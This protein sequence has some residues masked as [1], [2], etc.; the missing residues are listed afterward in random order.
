MSNNNL[1]HKVEDKKIIR[2]LQNIRTSGIRLTDL[3]N[4]LLDLSKLESGKMK[5][6]LKEQDL[7]LLVEQALSEVDSLLKEKLINVDIKTTRHFDCMIDR[8]L[9]TQVIIN[10]LSNS[11]KFSPEYS[12]IKI[13][14][15]KKCAY[16]RNL[17]PRQCHRLRH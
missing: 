3:L 12:S 5:A 17:H 4:D 13:G 6:D 8:K 1:L 11:I 2:Y 9:M 16:L 7:T 15:V 10:L 14:I